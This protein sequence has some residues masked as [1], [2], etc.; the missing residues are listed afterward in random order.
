M[1]WITFALGLMYV[2]AAYWLEIAAFF[3]ISI[4]VFFMRSE[5]KGKRLVYDTVD[6]QDEDEESE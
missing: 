6:Y 3:L 5:Y 2:I 1:I 4:I